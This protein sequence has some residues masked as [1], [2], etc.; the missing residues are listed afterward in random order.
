MGFQPEREVSA[1]TAIALY[2]SPILCKKARKILYIFPI[3]KIHPDQ[4]HKT[5]ISG[6]YPQVYA[7]MLPYL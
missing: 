7:H 6:P 2:I 4:P 5:P 3:D 1:V